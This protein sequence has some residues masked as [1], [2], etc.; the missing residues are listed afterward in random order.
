MLNSK[1]KIFCRYDKQM[2]IKTVIPARSE[3]MKKIEQNH[4]SLTKHTHLC[5]PGFPIQKLQSR[6]LHLHV[7][8]YD[9]FSRDDSIG[10]MFLPLCQVIRR[11]VPARNLRGS[12]ITLGRRGLGGS[13]V[14]YAVIRFATDT[15]NQTCVV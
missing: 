14:R 6:V 12:I 11:D 1:V 13:S 4:C 3:I 15:Q 10:E 5:H 7:F 8:D 9:R 2:V